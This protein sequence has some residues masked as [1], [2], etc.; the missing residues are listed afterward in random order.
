MKLNWI[1]SIFSFYFHDL[2]SLICSISS[3]ADNF[4]RAWVFVDSKRIVILK[5]KKKIILHDMV[6]FPWKF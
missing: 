3:L 5:K 1:V 6:G 2:R 4:S